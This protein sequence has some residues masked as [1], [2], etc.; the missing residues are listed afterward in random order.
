MTEL[1]SA[2]PK[3]S[4]TPASHPSSHKVYLDVEHAQTTLRV[5]ARRIHL[6]GDHGHLDVYDTSGPEGFEPRD[7]LPP[8]RAEWVKR[9]V[10]QG[11]TNVSQMHYARR[12]IVTEEM[13]YVA[14]REGMEPEFVREPM[15]IGRNFLVKINANIGNSAVTSS[16]EEEVEKLQS[17]RHT[18]ART[19]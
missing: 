8:L 9:R 10:L 4:E 18:G 5:P 2:T 12:G 15:I 7:G 17:G 11:D 1:S 16:I 6:S 13:A 14:A 19:R 3:A